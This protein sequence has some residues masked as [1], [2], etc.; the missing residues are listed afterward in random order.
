MST[1]QNLAGTSFVS[2]HTVSQRVLAWR[3]FSRNRLSVIGLIWVALI[4]ILGIIGPY[5]APHTYI[6]TNYLAANQGPSWQFPLGTDNLGHDMFSEVLYSIR[7]SCIIAFG[8]I[9]IS[10][11]IGAILGLWAGMAGGLIDNIIMRLVDLMF[12]FPAYFLNII[13]VV[14]LGRGLFPI[15]LSIGVTQWSG[16]A[17]LIRGLVISQKN[18]EMVEAARSLGATQ[19]H[20]A[21]HYLLPNIIGSIIVSLSFGLPNAMIQDAA[22]SVVGMGLRPPMPSFGNLL[23]AGG[24]NFLGFPWLLY[25]PAA[26]FAL[27]L[28]SFLFVGNGLQEALNPKGASK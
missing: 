15:F 28:L 11:M 21:R 14:D 16:Y 6:E 22:L 4:L 2:H 7:Y 20:I 3:R 13:L 10:F 9:A 26:I 5:I 27:T 18:G 25:C 12:A 24:S 19:S 17:R 23:S 8:A 1:V